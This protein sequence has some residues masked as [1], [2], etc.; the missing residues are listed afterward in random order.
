MALLISMSVLDSE[1]FP[2]LIDMMGI[3]L[4][5]SLENHAM[6]INPLLQRWS[7]CRSLSK[8]WRTCWELSGGEGMQQLGQS[9]MKTQSR[10]GAWPWWHIQ[11]DPKSILPTLDSLSILGQA[12]FFVP[13]FH[14]YCCISIGLGQ[15]HPD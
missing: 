15:A 8:V 3:F 1:F 7:P 6:H 2:Q 14:L 11:K 13:S 9:L 4:P 12:D 10:C 5:L